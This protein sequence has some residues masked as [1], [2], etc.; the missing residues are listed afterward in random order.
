MSD[1]EKYR[2][3]AEKIKIFNGFEPE[4]VG[5]FLKKGKTERCR[6]EKVIFRKGQEASGLYI[7]LSG[8]V[9]IHQGDNT[10]ARCESGDVFGEMS[11]LLHEPHSVTATALTP[12]KLFTLEVKQLNEILKT[13]VA[14]R[15]L[16]NIIQMLSDH[17]SGANRWVETLRK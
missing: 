9:G 1:T 17:L 16:V 5:D 8:V 10:I 11:A 7:V 3:Y 12:V 15:L 4:E 13:P 14:V 6:E 2:L